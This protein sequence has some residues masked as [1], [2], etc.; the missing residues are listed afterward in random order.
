[1]DLRVLTKHKR[2][3]SRI[4]RWR[5]HINTVYV[6]ST[7]LWGIRCFMEK[8]VPVN[9]TIEFQAYNRFGGKRRSIGL[10]LMPGVDRG[11][12][13]V[14]TRPLDSFVLQLEDE[15]ANIKYWETFKPPAMMPGFFRV[16]INVW[17]NSKT[18]VVACGSLDV[19]VCSPDRMLEL[20]GMRQK[21]RETRL[22]ILMAWTKD[23]S[24]YFHWLPMEVIVMIFEHMC[25]G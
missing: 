10:L 23:K 8:E 3:F 17:D 6:D 21:T 15:D 20:W 2:G 11:T 1:M 24:C 12:P 22:L 25:V 18:E 5:P 7:L 14:V 19:N 13:M 9:N 16:S 4:S